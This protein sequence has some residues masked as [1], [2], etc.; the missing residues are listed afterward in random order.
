MSQM[1][2]SLATFVENGVSVEIALERDDQDNFY[3]AATYTPTEPGYH[4]YANSLP[5]A[6]INGAGRP[7]LLE[8][9]SPQEV[10]D[11]GPLIAS[12]APLEERVNGFDRPF[13]V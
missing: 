7:T 1:T 12:T 11:V 2:V 4:L 3:L 10:E 9:V 6:G 8:I 13:P 5:R